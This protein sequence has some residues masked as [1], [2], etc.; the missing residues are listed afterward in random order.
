MLLFIINLDIFWCFTVALLTYFFI[1]SFLK[2]PSMYQIGGF[3]TTSII[4]CQAHLSVMSYAHLTSETLN[5]R[6][7][8]GSSFS[9]IV[10]S[11]T[12]IPGLFTL[13]CPAPTDSLTSSTL[14]MFTRKLSASS[15]I[16][17]LE[18]QMHTWKHEIIENRYSNSQWFL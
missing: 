6:I 8:R 1:T 7:P 18:K 16:S 11:A 12:S 4:Q 13:G 15:G 3:P 2:K 5:W 9:G 17:S 10:I 14:V